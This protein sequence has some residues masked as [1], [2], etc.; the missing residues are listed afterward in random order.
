MPDI[1]KAALPYL[2]L[3]IMQAALYIYATVHIL[4][5]D[6]FRSGT[7]NTWLVICL[8]FVGIGP[9]LYVIFGRDDSED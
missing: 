1:L 5:H 9:L 4:H 6:R 7:R 3:F 2:P 8:F